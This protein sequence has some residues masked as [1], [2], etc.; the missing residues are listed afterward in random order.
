MIKGGCKWVILNVLWA[1]KSL[2]GNL[3]WPLYLGPSCDSVIWLKALIFYDHIQPHAEAAHLYIKMFCTMMLSYP[4]VF[5]L[6]KSSLYSFAEWNWSILKPVL[7]CEFSQW[8]NPGNPVFI[9]RLRH[10]LGKGWVVVGTFWSS[11]VKT[12]FIY[13]KCRRIFWKEWNCLLSMPILMWLWEKDVLYNV[14]TVAP[15]SQ[16]ATCIAMSTLL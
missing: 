3:R 9:S 8:K 2:Q 5:Y 13:V 11:N 4:T 12:C 15:K 10:G 16:L 1:W 14:V 7:Q 6:R